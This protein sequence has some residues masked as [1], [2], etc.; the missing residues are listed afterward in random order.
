MP[1]KLVNETSP[2]LLQHAHNPVDWY[3]WGEEALKRARD[4]DKPILLSIGYSAC[5]WCHVMERESFENPE[6]AA[7]MN[8]HFISIKV[9]REERP[10]L[11]SLY[12][13]AVQAMTGSGGWPMTVFLTPEG[14]PFHGGTYFP[15]E[16][17]RGMPGFP[18]VL[19]SVAEAYGTR[20]EEINNATQQMV[21]HLEQ[22][23]QPS[24]ATD[25][26]T[27]DI[28]DQAFQ[29]LAQNYDYQYG[30]LGS[31]PKFP[32]PM[33]YE[34]LLGYHY[35]T[36]SD[37]ALQMVEMA[38]QNMARGGI[39]DQIG[40]GFHR[41][42]TDA[43]WLVP[44][45]EKML[46]DNAL[47]SRLILHAYQTTKS[48][49]Y[50]RIAEETLDYVLRE[51][52]APERGFY[53]T[54]DADSEGEEGKFFVWTPQEIVSVLGSEE[55]SLLG[56]Y[57]GV[58][59]H[60]NFE[61]KNI[62]HVP[63]GPESFAA[64]NGMTFEELEEVVASG[65]AR[66]LEA[67]ERRVHPARDE[68]ILTAWNGLMIRGFAEAASI[69]DRDDCRQAAVA[70]ASFVLGSMRK[71]GRLLRTYKNGEAKLK[72]YLEDYSFMI[73]GLLALYE[74]TFDNKWLAGARSLADDMIDLFWD[75][76]QG[77]FYDTGR[78]HEALVVRPRDVFDNAVP[79]GSSVATDV[80]LKLAVITGQADYSRH[81]STSLRSMQE[82]MSR[83]PTGAGHWL[84]ALSFYLSTPHEVAI[85]GNFDQ[86]STKA[87]LE[88]VFGN[89]LPN[90]V[91][92][93]SGP[94]QLEEGSEATPLLRDRVMVD[95]QPTAYV[96]Q[97][98]VCQLPVTEPA[99]LA[100]QLD[101]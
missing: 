1:N 3:P 46:Y 72:G 81:A 82:Y 41:Y 29:T 50:K 98:Y 56:R 62:L 34:F 13:T 21:A 8:E 53:S 10:D 94:G 35:L 48:P 92:T 63:Q 37:Q 69:M 60:G 16:D 17:S 22:T 42:S 39:Y 47:L 66:L 73:D 100:Q 40:G 96:C 24:R 95:G 83:A 19:L 85:V 28:L 80:L 54:Q 93:G 88:V 30:G 33:G 64:E 26:L 2:Y 11:D 74:A 97:N 7:L 99:A 61:G 23:V 9:D 57:W 5:H 43:Y 71:E 68:K 15:P 87:L 86:Q 32:Q 27:Q 25:M 77:A 89:Y 6:I 59:D 67:R 44:H 31:A 90:K 45:F 20:R 4:E 51:M 65:K 70:S 75:E 101:V 18:R 36:K 12:M 84:E 38:I 52:T 76:Q 55:G 79:S 91:V 49:F 58:S 14:K 78:D